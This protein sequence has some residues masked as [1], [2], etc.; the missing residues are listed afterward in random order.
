MC[1]ELRAGAS[2]VIEQA[3]AVHGDEITKEAE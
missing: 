2:F 3:L 1:A